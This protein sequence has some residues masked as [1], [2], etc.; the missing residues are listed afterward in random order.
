MDDEILGA[1]VRGTATNHV[2]L[3]PRL[4]TS[5]RSI[6]LVLDV[7]TDVFSQTESRKQAATALVEGVTSIQGEKVIEFDGRRIVA[8]PS[9]AAA[10][11][12]SRIVDFQWDRLF[13][14]K[15]ALREAYRTKPDSEAVSARKAAARAERQID[16]QVDSQLRKWAAELRPRVRDWNNA[17][18]SVSYQFSSQP[19]GVEF[20]ARFDQTAP[21]Q[22][23]PLPPQMHDAEFGVHESFVNELIN[24][25]LRDRMVSEQD[26]SAQ[27]GNLLPAR[28]QSLEV[29]D[30]DRVWSLHFGQQPLKLEIDD[31]QIRIRLEVQGLAVGEDSY[32][33]ISIEAL[34]QLT[35]ATA[36]D[37][38]P[39]VVLQRDKRL[40]LQIS[41]G[42]SAGRLGVRQQVFRSMVRKRFEP[43]FADEIPLG[44]LLMRKPE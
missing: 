35:E 16:E 40:A 1:R 25:S 4:R 23:V 8:W 22:G 7:Q 34:Y 36:S 31:N 9:G 5:E 15:I 6:V 3:S 37:G 14:E 38:L 33:G 24:Q 44:T 12:Q 29:A 11:T 30:P 32:P 10:D 27:F 20:R 19:D 28:P 43:I 42:K 41:Q 26:W 18:L 2:R 13:G 39:T 17:G 21:S